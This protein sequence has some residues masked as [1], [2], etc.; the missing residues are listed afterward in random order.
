MGGTRR[1]SIT[2]PVSRDTPEP[3]RTIEVVFEGSPTRLDR[4][5]ATLEEIASRSAAERLISEGNVRVNG[6]VRDKAWM[7]RAGDRVEVRIPAPEPSGLV[8]YEIDL[9]V[10]YE[11]EDLMVICKPAG[12]VTHPAYGHA[13]DTLVNALI[14]RNERLSTIGGEIRPGIV[15]RLDKDTSGLM[16]V[17]RND[18]AHL[19]L[20]R[21]LKE[22]RIKRNYLALTCGVIHRSRFEVRA[23]IGKHRGTFKKMA[24][25][26]LK[27]KDAATIFTVRETFERFTLVEASLLTGRTHQ[28]RVHLSSIGHPVAGDPLYGGLKCAKELPLSRLFLHAWRLEF[29]HPRTGVP[30]AFEDTLPEELERVLAFLRGE[31]R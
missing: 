20:S 11:D 14:A 21:A 19:A 6:T 29:E 1:C 9:D 31:G 18:A 30:L 2:V 23:P 3:E 8:P 7:L 5:V 13:N 17:A 15:H 4:F 25:D 16:L 27:G 26:A 12:L 10:R 24:V 22:R 28:I